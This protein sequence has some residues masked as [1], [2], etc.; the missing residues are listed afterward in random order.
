MPFLATNLK[1]L[2]H[3]HHGEF[4]QMPRDYIV[5]N[6]YRPW[7]FG[8]IFTKGSGRPLH[9]TCTP[10]ALGV[11]QHYSTLENPVAWCWLRHLID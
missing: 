7:C 2:Y 6:T 1:A 9:D 4:Q 3:A 10:M 8:S 11:S 5:D